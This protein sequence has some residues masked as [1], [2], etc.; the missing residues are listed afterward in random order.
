MVKLK[1]H[2][3]RGV[4]L[5]VCTAESKIAYNMAFSAHISF[6]EKWDKARAEKLPAFIFNE[7]V[8]DI[9]EFEMNSYRCAYDYKPGKYNEDAIQD[10]L[11][12]GLENYMDNPFIASDYAKIGEVFKSWY[13]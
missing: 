12:W 2:K 7:F 8:Y 5:E 1:Y 11:R 6:Q 4:P 9:I 10:C 3:I 13:L